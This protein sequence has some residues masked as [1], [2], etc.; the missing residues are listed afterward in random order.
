LFFSVFFL[1]ASLLEKRAQ[2][3]HVLGPRGVELCS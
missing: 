2:A 1:S 3:T